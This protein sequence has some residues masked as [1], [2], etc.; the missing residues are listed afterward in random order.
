M[1]QIPDTPASFLLKTRLNDLGSRAGVFTPE[2]LAM[3][4]ELVQIG[5][6]VVALENLCMEV[7]DLDVVLGL[8][9]AAELQSLCE[10]LEVDPKYWTRL[11]PPSQSN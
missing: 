8:D 9:V 6:E 2:R 1:R 10:S 4:H 7:A 5:E 3:Y 11:L